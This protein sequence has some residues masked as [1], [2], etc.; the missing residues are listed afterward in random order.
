MDPH[1]QLIESRYHFLTLSSNNYLYGEDYWIQYL[2]E[3]ISKWGIQLYMHET[4]NHQRRRTNDTFLMDGI[5]GVVKNPQQLKQ[6]NDV[7]LFLEVALLSDLST[8]DGFSFQNW[9]W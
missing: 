8:P 2:W 5:V 4:L 6:I 9:A 3:I 7:R 1:Q